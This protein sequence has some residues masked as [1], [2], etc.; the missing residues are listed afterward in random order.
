MGD[1]LSEI[2]LSQNPG[3]PL[4]GIE[5]EQDLSSGFIE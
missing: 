5:P 1:K 3:T 2:L 4:S